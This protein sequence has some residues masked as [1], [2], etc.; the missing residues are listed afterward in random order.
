MALRQRTF[1]GRA[2]LALIQHNRLIIDDS[3][4]IEHV[5]IGA[6]GERT[7]PGIEP[8]QPQMSRCLE[9]HHVGRD[10]D[11]GA[12]VLGDFV[13]THELNDSVVRLAQDL[14]VF[15]FRYHR[16]DHLGTEHWDHTNDVSSGEIGT[17]CEQCC[18]HGD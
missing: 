17:E 1:K 9:A 16:F 14:I 10:T 13:A 11:A 3:P 6:D 18:V 12:P 5:G 8:T 4:L 2:G 7:T 15:Q